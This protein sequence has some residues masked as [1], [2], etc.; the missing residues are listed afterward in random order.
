[1]RGS[2]ANLFLAML[3]QT[4]LTATHFFFLLRSLLRSGVLVYDDDSSVFEFEWI[5]RFYVIS[6]TMWKAVGANFRTEFN[7]FLIIFPLIGKVI[8]KML[9]T[10]YTYNIYC[11][12]AYDI[13][14]DRHPIH[15]FQ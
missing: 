11:Q 7:D 6:F 5:Y 3:K 15:H 9:Y 1:M 13:C 2:L 4:M 12:N 10:I 14:A 8:G